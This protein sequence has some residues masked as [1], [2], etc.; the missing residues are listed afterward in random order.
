LRHCVRA[1]VL[2]G[3]GLIAPPAAQPHARSRPGRDKRV[4]WIRPRPATSTSLTGS[5][6]ISPRSAMGLQPAS[7][8]IG[9][10]PQGPQCDEWVAWM[11]SARPRTRVDAYPLLLICRDLLRRLA[12]RDLRLV[13]RR[14]DALISKPVSRYL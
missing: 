10:R 8:G 13:S 11:Q 4:L 3:G 12:A 9:A 7:D 6:H 2:G 1:C 14:A 5:Q